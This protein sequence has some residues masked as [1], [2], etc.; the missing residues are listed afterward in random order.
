VLP[1]MQRVAEAFGPPCAV[2][3]LSASMRDLVWRC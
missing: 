3:V 2:S 1:G